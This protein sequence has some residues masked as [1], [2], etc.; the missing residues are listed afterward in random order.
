MSF[1]SRAT[2]TGRR[3][4]GIECDLDLA[5]VERVH[6]VRGWVVNDEPSVSLSISSRLVYRS[7]LA[8]FTRS[9]TRLDDLKGLWALEP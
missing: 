2:T 6:E 5:R 8:E 1:S 3:S 7:D 4:F 9:V